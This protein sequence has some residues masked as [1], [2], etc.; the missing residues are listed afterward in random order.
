MDASGVIQCETPFR[1]VEGAFFPLEILSKKRLSEKEKTRYVYPFCYLLLY[2]F[3]STL[4]RHVL[5]SL[6]PI[7]RH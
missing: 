5:F 6:L 2:C 1:L 3:F 4:R 7:F